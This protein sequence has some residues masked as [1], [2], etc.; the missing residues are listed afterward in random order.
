MESDAINFRKH[1]LVENSIISGSR[2]GTKRRRAAMSGVVKEFR[3]LM[4]LH[5]AGAAC[6]LTEPTITLLF[7]G[8]ARFFLLTRSKVSLSEN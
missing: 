6:S 2:E 5:A 1:I 4:G 3:K 7:S 8:R